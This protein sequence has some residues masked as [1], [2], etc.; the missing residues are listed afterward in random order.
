MKNVTKLLLVLSV[1]ALGFSSCSKEKR[2]ER[3]L[4]SR[5][6]K[7]NN[8]VY[9]YKYYNN[10]VLETSINYVDAGNIEFDKD[11]TYVWT[12]TAD[13]NTEIDAG[14]WENSEDDITLFQNSVG[15]KFKILEESR[16]EMKLEY[17][18]TYG[19]EREV[20][21]LTFEKDN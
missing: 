10:G 4:Y 3:H 18:E 16:K 21:V 1:F 12:F 17:T 8:T 2:I 20:Y 13:G 15:L 9:D 6:G 19:V 5:S 7:W 11:G 14:T